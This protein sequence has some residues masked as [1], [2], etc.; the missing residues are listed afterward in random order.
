MS[1][2]AGRMSV[3]AVEMSVGAGRMSADTVRM[4]API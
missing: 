4:R 1:A 2:G 3:D